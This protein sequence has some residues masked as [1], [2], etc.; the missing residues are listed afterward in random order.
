MKYEE[1]LLIFYHYIF[2][3]VVWVPYLR[4]LELGN[5]SHLLLKRWV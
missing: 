4:W 3:R 2:K 1:I 5:Q